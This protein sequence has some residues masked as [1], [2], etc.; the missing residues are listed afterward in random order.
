MFVQVIEAKVGDRHKLR[1]RID[2]WL[3]EVAPDATGWLGHT[4]GVA[5]DGT[6]FAA[7]RFESAEA[8]RTNSDRPEQGA[9]WKETTQCLEGDV[10]VVDCSEVDMLG[11]RGG[12]DDAG[13]VQ[14]IQGRGD[15]HALLAATKGRQELLA[16]LRPDVLGA[17]VAWEGEGR[18][19]QLVYFTSEAA[20][21][22]GEKRRAVIM[23]AVQ[24]DRFI[25]LREPWFASA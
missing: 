13:F 9:W 16:R 10:R 15:R 18:F 25:D 21:R 11:S 1:S 4:A 14:V 6:F 5:A 19:N 2:R 20:A 12:S 24:F 3:Q 7:V 22:E 23:S 17:Y 8:A